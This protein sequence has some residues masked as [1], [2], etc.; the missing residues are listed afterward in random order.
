M[1]PQATV[2]KGITWLCS[3]ADMARYS[4]FAR[5]LMNAFRPL[6]PKS[7]CLV[8]AR[9]RLWP[10]IPL[11]AFLLGTASFG[12]S[13]LQTAAK[14]P[15]RA[16]SLT[17]AIRLAVKQN[18]TLA[19]A[20]SDVHSAHA[21]ILEASGL[22]DF[23]V[24]GSANWLSN[25]VTLLDVRLAQSATNQ[26]GFAA[27]LTRPLPTGGRLGLRLGA[28]WTQ[29]ATAA[30]TLPASNHR[31]TPS[32]FLTFAHPLLKGA[33]VD[34]GRAD[35]RRAQSTRAIAQLQRQMVATGLL[36]DVSQAYWDLAR[37]TRQLEI[38]RA[39]LEQAKRQLDVVQANIAVG[40]Q[41]PSASAEVEVAIALRHE[42]VL[43]SEQDVQAQA[44]ELGRL[45][46]FGEG[47]LETQ[48]VAAEA[49]ELEA[50]QLE[51][52]ALLEEALAQSPDLQ[53]AKAQKSA[54]SVEV[55]VTS[56]ALRPQVDIALSGGPVGNAT[57]PLQAMHELVALRGYSVQASLILST[58]VGQ[59][60]ARGQQAAALEG[61]HKAQLSEGEVTS[62]LRASVFGAVD[63]LK[64]SQARAQVLEKATQVAALD[65]ESAQARFAG[66]RAT[67]FDVLRRQDELTLTQLREVSA[68]ADSL[69]AVA[70]LE[71]LTAQILSRHGIESL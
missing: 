39:S 7:S 59:R 13:A 25:H 16:I 67:N 14:Q 30:G 49:P 40:K 20:I 58:A 17:E 2:F 38:R 10:T 46:G 45:L 23:I 61:L 15:A 37:A 51:A 21:R 50:T 52:T 26:I 32:I 1:V 64:K 28:N 70:T 68:N 9:R 43:L 57:T 19:K 3:V 24:D 36:R 71:A 22:D 60:A 65:L 4:H 12:E 29:F 69:K 5:P 55:D 62:Q 47:A 53:L 31:F 66:G 18:P 44:L 35:R 8:T 56:N 54:A 63:V 34:I 6:G 11:L 27:S 33:G 41:P 42:D 48:L